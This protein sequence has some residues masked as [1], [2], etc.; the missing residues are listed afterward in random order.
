MKPDVPYQ[1]VVSRDAT[2]LEASGPASPLTAN[3]NKGSKRA[4]SAKVISPWDLQIAR[5]RIESAHW[6]DWLS[7]DNGQNGSPS[8]GIAKRYDLRNYFFLAFS[9]N[10]RIAARALRLPP[11]FGPL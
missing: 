11:S 1:R 5:M 10:S 3:A 4:R 9:C 7:T 2:D 6:R 8:T